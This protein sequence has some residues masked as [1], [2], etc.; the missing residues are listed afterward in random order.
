MNIKKV[1]LFEANLEPHIDKSSKV[2]GLKAIFN[3][4]ESDHLPIIDIEQLKNLSRIEMTSNAIRLSRENPR[5]D[6]L[7]ISL[8]RSGAPLTLSEKTYW[9]IELIARAFRVLTDSKYS[10]SQVLDIILTGMFDSPVSQLEDQIV[11]MFDRAKIKQ[12]EDYIF[13]T[14]ALL[15]K[16]FYTK[17]KENDEEYPEL[18]VPTASYHPVSLFK[19]L[20]LGIIEPK[21]LSDVEFISVI[22]GFKIADVRD[23]PYPDRARKK[24]ISA[25]VKHDVFQRANIDFFKIRDKHKEILKAYPNN[26]I[27][28]HMDRYEKLD[29]STPRYRRDSFLGLSKMSYLDDESLNLFIER[30]KLLKSIAPYA[31]NFSSD[32]KR[33][34]I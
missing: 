34:L 9:L 4:N 32:I 17:S 7:H 28:Q 19:Y 15:K 21:L 1:S 33:S 14:K 10:N 3:A 5:E 26:S 24:Q 16:V 13:P 29:S 30:F 27:R 20:L 2:K 12:A 25:E 11:N 22:D 18:F 8:R 31:G 6:H 23:F